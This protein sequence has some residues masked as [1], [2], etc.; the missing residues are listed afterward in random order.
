MTPSMPVPA[1]SVPAPSDAGLPGAAAAAVV[2]AFVRA[3]GGVGLTL[4]AAP[5][6]TEAMRV[7]EAGGYR[8]RFPAVE[9]RHCEAVLI[10]TGGGMTGGDTMRVEIEAG[11][12][13]DAVVT[14][15]A[16]EKIYRSQGADT[17]VDVS[18]RLASG[19]SFAWLPQETILFDGSRLRRSL[20]ID[21]AGD[22]RLLMAESLFFGR[23][24]MGESFA[25]GAF[26]DRW[27]LRRDGRL[28]LAEGVRIED[29]IAGTLERAP[30]G[31]GA[32]AVA[33]LVC[34]APDAES[35][36]DEARAHLEGAV[37]EC[38]ASAW[39]GLLVVRMLCREAAALRADLVRFLVAFRGMAMPRSW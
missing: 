38:G 31:G 3:H 12:G 13:A 11:E 29:D 19:A 9:G 1:S 7:R 20:E 25:R 37:S 2:P 4:T 8:V 21:L 30:L 17:R 34:V 28:V 35:R 36:L 18:I 24:A 22:A 23:A 39:D 16:A 33:T 10:N 14:T 5:R 26:R 32:R 15:Q 6:G 27:R